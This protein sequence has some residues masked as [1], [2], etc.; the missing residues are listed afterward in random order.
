ME[1]FASYGS[2][3]LVVDKL[4]KSH[5]KLK[6]NIEDVGKII[7]FALIKALVKALKIDLQKK[8]KNPNY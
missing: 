3:R 4:I 5:P 1:L 8:E 6:W 7:H 2:Y